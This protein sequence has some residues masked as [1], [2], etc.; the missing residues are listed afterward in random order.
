MCSYYRVYFPDC[1]HFG[2][3]VHTICLDAKK[4]GCRCVT[5]IRMA[6]QR[7]IQPHCTECRPVDDAWPLRLITMLA[8]P[9]LIAMEMCTYI[10]ETLVWSLAGCWAYMPALQI[11]MQY[12]GQSLEIK[13]MATDSL[14]GLVW[15]LW[16]IYDFITNGNIKAYTVPTLVIAYTVFPEPVVTGRLEFV[17]KYLT[18]F[19]FT[20][21]C[22]SF[23][24]EIWPATTV[25]YRVISIVV[26]MLLTGFIYESSESISDAWRFVSL[27]T[28]AA[29]GLPPVWWMLVMLL[30]P[31]ERILPR[32]RDIPIALRK[33]MNA[34]WRVA[35]LPFRLPM[36]FHNWFDDRFVRRKAL[37]YMPAP[38]DGWS[39]FAGQGR[40]SQ[41]GMASKLEVEASD[42]E[43]G[44]NAFLEE[45]FAQLRRGSY[46]RRRPGVN[47]QTSASA[48][49]LRRRN[50]N[51]IVEDE[52]RSPSPS[53]SPELANQDRRGWLNRI[54]PKA[55]R[56]SSQAS[57]ELLAAVQANFQRRF[58]PKP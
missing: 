43:V 44:Q 37:P 15:T 57:K 18:P 50:L 22:K 55:K 39:V 30:D 20:S 16:S 3:E 13:A 52:A 35:G 38:R 46:E 40:S 27:L 33:G 1:G 56:N 11:N 45:P 34:S 48:S 9:F 25:M 8:L 6:P 28:W 49:P 19:Q 14:Y 51:L 32:Q 10:L 58:K 7:R 41:L 4:R 53:S 47:E 17:I 31:I 29:Y 23:V 2:Q 36:V 26:L 12:R 24:T 54:R 21:I 42:E 5:I